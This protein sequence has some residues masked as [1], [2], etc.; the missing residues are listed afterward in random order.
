MNI[1]I[2]S[3]AKKERSTYDPLY[4][5]LIKMISRFAKVDDTELF[6]KDVTKAHTISPEA[7]KAVYTKI[8]EPYISKGFNVILHPD[9][10]I[11]DSYEF[12]K[13]L[14]DKIAIK[15]FIGGAYGFENDFLKNGDAVISL[16]NIT[17]SHKIAKVVLLEQIYR[18]FSILSNHPYH[19]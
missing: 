11:I 18:G 14:D 9:G 8:L 4:K 17:M 13:L 1:E 16:G 15:F 5:E 6:N 12:S 2:I 7:S 3:I 19:K 10:K